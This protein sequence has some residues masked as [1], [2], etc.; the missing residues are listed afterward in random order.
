VAA[1]TNG[2]LGKRVVRGVGRFFSNPQY[3]IISLLAYL[4]LC[5][6]LYILVLCKLPLDYD[7]AGFV[8]FDIATGGDPHNFTEKLTTSSLIWTYALGIHF[9]SW[10]IM[11][12]LIAMVVDAAYKFF[13]ESKIKAEKKV[14]K[15]I[16]QIGRDRLDLSGEALDEFVD[17]QLDKM[18]QE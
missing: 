1:Q 4:G 16:R 17:E 13:E 7:T 10:L 2:A 5:L 6:F 18:R 3:L 15:R 9:L 12:V 14:E 11:P 8:T